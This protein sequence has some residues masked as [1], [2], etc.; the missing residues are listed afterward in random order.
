MSPPDDTLDAALNRH[1]ITL[2]EEQI[3]LLGRYCAL[4]WEWNRKI[5]LTRHADYEKFVG[6][7]V[8][9]AL[10]FSRF[11]RR[12]EW[13]LDVGSGGGVPGVLLAILRPDLRLT[14]SESVA[15]KARILNDIVHNLELKSLVFSGRA[16]NLL[17]R[18]R[19]HTLIGRAVAPLSKILTWLK[20]HWKCFDRLLLLKGPSWTDER[21]EARHYGHLNNL[22]LR[23]LHSYFLP[24]S[25][26]KSVL[27]LICP[28]DR[29]EEQ[30]PKKDE[31]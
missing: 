13:V 11:L 27:L 8:V 3:V 19:F 18:Q 2:P 12:S 17:P 5:N 22:A 20:P 24:N 31:G 25:D 30:L 15:K 10:V 21:A 4:L 6:R 16:E 7:D 23:K 29:L 26:A 1:Q 28:K 9:D 14:L